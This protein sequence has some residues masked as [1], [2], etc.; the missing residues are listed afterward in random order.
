MRPCGRSVA[1]SS[2]LWMAGRQAIQC[3]GVK[4]QWEAPPKRFELIWAAIDF[5]GT[6]AS[7]EYTPDNP[8]YAIGEPMPKALDKCDELVAVGYKIIIHTARPWSDYEV[9]ESWLN[10]HG[11]PWSKI[12]CGKLLADIYIDDRAYNASLDSWVVTK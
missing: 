11:F 12:V 6:I 7:S 5:D 8:T 4:K 3:P 1:H 9:V 2:H 10:H